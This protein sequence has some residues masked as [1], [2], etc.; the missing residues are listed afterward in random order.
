M[1][2]DAIRTRL[3]DI[4]RIA[5][6]RLA[7]GQDASTVA[8]DVIRSIRAIAADDQEWLIGTAAGAR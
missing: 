1:D 4:A 8:D 2:T 6:A 3:Y 7:R 5:E